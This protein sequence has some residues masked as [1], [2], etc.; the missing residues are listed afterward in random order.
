M[1]KE[2][3]SLHHPLI[4]H[5]V[6]VRQNSDYRYDH[7]TCVV[8]G[9]KLVHELCRTTIP[10]VILAVREELIPPNVSSGDVFIVSEE[11]MDKASGLQNPEGILAEIDL[12]SF[13]SLNGKR[14]LIALDGINDPGNLGA[15]LRTALALGWEGAFLFNHCCDPFNEK[16]VRAAKGATFRLPLY[17]GTEMELVELIQKNCADGIVAD[18]EGT[19]FHD[20]PGSK[21]IVLILGNEA[22]GPSTSISKVCK[23]VSI[24]MPG[25]ME[26]LNVAVAGGIL[27]YGLRPK[28]GK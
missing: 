23:K 8:E 18:L 7:Q 10:K 27:M 24:P 16:A 11:V 6:K 5:L 4:K 13:K 9:V 15:V 21:K 3:Q 19:Y 28:E 26:S 1:R 2:I 14:F 22:H 17:E 25:E 20:I 12:P